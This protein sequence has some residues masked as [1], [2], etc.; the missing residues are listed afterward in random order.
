MYQIFWSGGTSI[1]GAIL[2]IILGLLLLIFPSMSG[3]VFVWALAA[4]T[5][6]YGIGRLF[7]Y[8]RSRKDGNPATG[9]AFLAII[10]LAFALFCALRPYALL[11]FLPLVLGLLCLLDGVVKVP[12]AVAFVRERSG[13]ALVPELISTIL[14]IILGVLL[15]ANPFGAARIAIMVFGAGLVLDGVSDL[16]TAILSRK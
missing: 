14:P 5:A 9:E 15:L 10:A 6:I 12:V 16:A 4:G 3:T 13:G 7:R 8:F 1:W 11:S 2:Y